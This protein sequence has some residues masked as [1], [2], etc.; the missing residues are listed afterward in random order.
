[1]NRVRSLLALP[2]ALVLL[3]SPPARAED[4]P[5]R[6]AEELLRMAEA[7]EKI[8][9]DASKAIDL[10][11]RA[12]AAEASPSTKATALARLAALLEETGR[13]DEA[14]ETYR[15]L[16]AAL[17]KGDGDP[18]LRIR[19][20]LGLARSLER[21]GRLAEAAATLDLEEQFAFHLDAQQ[22][23]AI[24]DSLARLRARLVPDREPVN[25]LDT[26]LEAKVRSLLKRYDE[27]PKAEKIQ[28]ERE[29]VELLRPVGAGVIPALERQIR[30]ASP[31]MAAFAAE[32]VARIG[33]TPGID[34][35]ERIAADDR[36][37]FAQGA[38]LSGLLTV[39]SSPERSSR[40]LAAA[41]RLMEVPSLAD[42]RES[43]LLLATSHASGEEALDRYRR[44]E[45]DASAWL[46]V[47]LL[48]RAEG[49]VAV[50]A[51]VARGTGKDAARAR[52]ALVELGQS[53]VQAASKGAPLLSAEQVD[54]IVD[55][56]LANEA[57]LDH[58]QL[59]VLGDLLR[60]RLQATPPADR[61]RVA[62][63]LWRRALEV[64]TSARR[65]RVV[66]EMLAGTP[67]ERLSI[68]AA[69]WADE[70]LG[71]EIV[72]LGAF[73]SD[74]LNDL[75]S[76]P[77][78][79]PQWDAVARALP[80]LT[81][82][83]AT[84]V[85]GA[86]GAGQPGGFAAPPRLGAAWIDVLR[87]LPLDPRYGQV[88]WLVEAAARS[89]DPAYLDLVREN[90]V[91]R[92]TP[93]GTLLLKELRDYGGPGRV[94]LALDLLRAADDDAL[95]VG[96]EI[97]AR[98]DDPRARES[99]EEAAAERTDRGAKAVIT[100]ARLGA[101]KPLVRLMQ[102]AYVR[103]DPP[104]SEAYLLALVEAARSLRTREA[105]PFLLQQFR[106][107]RLNVSGV[108][109][110]A[111]EEIRAYHERLEDFER[112]TESQQEDLDV[113]LKDPDPEIRRAAVL[114]VAASGGRDVLPRLVRIAKDEKEPRVRAAALQAVERIAA[115]EEAAAKPPETTVPA[116]TTPGE[117]K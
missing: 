38:A 54:G 63:A 78:D 97:L 56:M 96:L 28:V 36:D 74:I 29:I 40:L 110:K 94:D 107:G 9:R 26:P 85:L 93:L 19:A 59:G 112:W 67:H 8:D 58:A 2:F 72:R 51:Q 106:E 66:S 32:L 57:A 48:R 30:T 95:S 73:A 47:A 86:L 113:L 6:F 99:L 33:G 116:P 52:A 117:G 25:R 43:L 42:R 11:R 115:R 46:H 27:A 22:R 100:L 50:A 105:V 60:L 103:Q 5:P 89:G 70:T 92:A 62:A 77:N 3:A 16:D 81:P 31:T 4:E 69:T 39:Q 75:R 87:R 13:L 88:R 101:T 10:Y 12:L 17:A 18:R 111:L 82:Q 34:L 41:D 45:P 24:A 71:P 1:M 23:V 109:G 83:A 90:V 84:S 49:A 68:P 80:G 44:G 35:L 7:A 91:P 61:D 14:I 65:A 20:R 15:A 76:I 104:A 64:G 98:S 102:P 79:G 21:S 55:V 108:A 53:N 114:A 37:G